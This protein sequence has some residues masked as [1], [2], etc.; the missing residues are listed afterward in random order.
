MNTYTFTMTT[1]GGGFPSSTNYGFVKA[2]NAT[3][4]EAILRDSLE[5]FTIVSLVFSGT[6]ATIAVTR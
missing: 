2:W 6:D 5:N 4:A 3:Q 1:T